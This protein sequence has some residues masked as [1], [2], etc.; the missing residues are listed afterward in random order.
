[1]CVCVWVGLEEEEREK[2]GKSNKRFVFEFLLRP[3][4]FT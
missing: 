3:T 2:R 1:M 4:H